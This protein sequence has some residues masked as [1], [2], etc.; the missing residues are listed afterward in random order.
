MAK[1]KKEK[2]GLAQNR[3]YTKEEWDDIKKALSDVPDV[4]TG[5]SFVTI[6]KYFEGQK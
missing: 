2:I 3:P 6:D 1:N 4:L 5:R